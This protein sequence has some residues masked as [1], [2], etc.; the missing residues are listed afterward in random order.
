MIAVRKSNPR[1]CWHQT[2][3]AMLP[4]IHRYADLAFRDLHGDNH[5]DA[6][7][8]VVA[9]TCVAF[10]RLVEQGREDKAFPTVLARFAISQVRAGRQVGASLNVRD[11]L[12]RHARRKKGFVVERL[13]R[14][15]RGHERWIEA[16]IE[17]PSTPVFDQVWF[18]IDF[19]EWLSQ[20]SLRKREIAKAL[21]IGDSTRHVA[22]RFGVSSGRISQLR[23][24]LYDSWLRF[25]GEPIPPTRAPKND[26]GSSQHKGV[27]N[28]RG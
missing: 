6:V 15:D 1:P 24:E 8:E 22:K 10:A 18:R 27:V 23:R 21:A 26:H 19:P 16:V 5:D 20:L 28:S 13:D 4:T 12:S 2:F 25:H 14:M 9:N 11:V 7:Q 3:L 17:D